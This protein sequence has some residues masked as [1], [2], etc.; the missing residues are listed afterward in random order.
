M[1]SALEIIQVSLCGLQSAINLVSSELDKNNKAVKG[2]ANSMTFLQMMVDN[3]KLRLE[4]CEKKVSEVQVAPKRNNLIILGLE[5]E[6]NESHS[7]TFGIL[8][9]FLKEK[10]GILIAE[11]HVDMVNRLGRGRGK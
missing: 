5:E 4:H 9:K 3:M 1:K 7:T 8:E 10:M 6:K 11:W 2:L